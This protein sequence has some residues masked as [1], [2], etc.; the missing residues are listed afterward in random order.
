M[1]FFFTFSA[2]PQKIRTTGKKIMKIHQLEQILENFSKCPHDSPFWFTVTS[3]LLFSSS[4][5]S[6]FPLP[7]PPPPFS[8][9][10]SS[11]LNSKKRYIFKSKAVRNHTPP[12]PQGVLAPSLIGIYCLWTIRKNLFLKFF[13]RSWVYYQIWTKHKYLKFFKNMFSSS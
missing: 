3:P 12:P 2:A 9:S 1:N 4:K 5:A 8:S 11:G 6:G 7:P 10:Y 13:S